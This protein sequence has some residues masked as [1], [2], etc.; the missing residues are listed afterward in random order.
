MRLVDPADGEG[1]HDPLVHPLALERLLRIEGAL[2]L[3][4]HDPVLVERIIAVAVKLFR[5]QPFARAERIRRVND[6]QVVC[7]PF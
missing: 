2:I 1:L 3:V 6:D 5:E 4:D 7:I